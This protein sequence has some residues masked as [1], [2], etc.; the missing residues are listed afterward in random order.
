[1]AGQ[2]QPKIHSPLKLTAQPGILFHGISDPGMAFAKGTASS[3]PA[4]A[5]KR[6]EERAGGVA[7]QQNN[8]LALYFSAPGKIMSK[9]GVATQGAKPRAAICSAVTRANSGFSGGT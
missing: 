9:P 2:L 7:L 1:M 5:S 3:R 4:V 8:A 6:A